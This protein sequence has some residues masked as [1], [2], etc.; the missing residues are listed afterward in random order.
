MKKSILPI[1]LCAAS[2]LSVACTK[3]YY[4][5]APVR[6]V[7]SQSSAPVKAPANVSPAVD[8]FQA[9]TKP[10]SYSSY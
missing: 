1:A 9:V 5:T 3:N 2:L 8:G 10:T 6:T 4:Y 7:R